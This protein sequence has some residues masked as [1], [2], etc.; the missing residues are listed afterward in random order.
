MVCIH[1]LRSIRTSAQV[2]TTIKVFYGDRVTRSLYRT[3]YCVFQFSFH[4][5]LH[6]Q[7][8]KQSACTTSVKRGQLPW[9]VSFKV[10][11]TSRRLV[12]GGSRPQDTSCIYSRTSGFSELI[13]TAHS[14]DKQHFGYRTF[15]KKINFFFKHT[16]L[17]KYCCILLWIKYLLLLL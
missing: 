5:S 11:D 14:S 1:V 3:K 15:F 17:L 13:G 4:R 12:I 10:S 9:Y 8:R 2:C 16:T 6:L 7:V